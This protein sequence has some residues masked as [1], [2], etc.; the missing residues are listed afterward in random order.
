MPGPWGVK[1]GDPNQHDM[2]WGSC[3]LN[4]EC[5]PEYRIYRGDMYCGR[6]SFVCCALE[7]TTYDMYQGFDVSF[8]GKS[9]STDTEEIFRDRGKKRLNKK[10]RKEARIRRKKKIKRTIKSIIREINKILARMYTNATRRRKRKTKQLKRFI[11]FLK[12][13]YKKNRHVVQDLHEQAIVKIDGDLMKKLY[14]IK[15]MNHNF[16]RNHTFADIVVNGTM[17]KQGARMLIQAYPELQDFIDRPSSPP[18][19]VRKSD[20]GNRRFGGGVVPD[21]EDKQDNKTKTRHKKEGDYLEYDVEYGFLY[22]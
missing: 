16:M 1:C 18:T 2:P 19:I 6:T 8:E 12:T 10:K 9:L 14:D 20:L 4:M 7:L 22:Y 3:M 5:D 13:E 11:K 17:T 21:S 15:D